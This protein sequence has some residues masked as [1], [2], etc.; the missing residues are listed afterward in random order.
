MMSLNQ[1]RS[2]VLAK[3]P[4]GFKR[5]V[6]TPPE[7]GLKV[8]LRQIANRRRATAAES[9]VVDLLSRAAEMPLET[10]V[11]RVAEALYR[12][13]LRAGAWAVDVGLFGSG[14]FVAEARRTLE[15]GNGELWEIG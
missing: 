13:E 3:I 7:T 8:R 15:S 4:F 6:A 9:V 12:E 11:A 10:L 14:L 2:G 5:L 1:L